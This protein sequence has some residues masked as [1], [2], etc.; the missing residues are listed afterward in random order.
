MPLSAHF[1]SERSGPGCTKFGVDTGQSAKQL[2]FILLRYK[3]KGVEE[4]VKIMYCPPV[5]LKTGQMSE[6]ILAPNS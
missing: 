2:C 5:K 4:C 6:F 1:F 3:D